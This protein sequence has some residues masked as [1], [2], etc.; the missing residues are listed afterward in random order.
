MVGQSARSL[1]EGNSATLL[2]VAAFCILVFFVQ[3]LAGW[4]VYDRQAILNGQLWRL[5]TGHLVHFTRGHLLFDLLGFLLAG[6]I[7]R[8]RGYAGFWML[9]VISAL[10]IS[11]ALMLDP[12]VA[13]FGGIS[14]VVN[15]AVVFIVARQVS[16]PG[17]WRWVSLAILILAAGNSVLEAATGRPTFAIPGEQTFVPVPL[18]HMIGGLT[19]ALMGMQ[20]RRGPEKTGN[21]ESAALVRRFNGSRCH[22]PAGPLHRRGHRGLQQDRRRA[23]RE[24]P[25]E[26][27]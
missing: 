24:V 14:G 5:L 16:E 10:A 9:C 23:G 3:G 2:L 27:I 1:T 8:R 11:G 26:G 18:A 17:R 13:S 22:A 19:G 15:A 12:E 25:G 20:F 7:I 4:L 6:W 21:F